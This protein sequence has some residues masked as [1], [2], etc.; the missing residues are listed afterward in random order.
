MH[1]PPHVPFSP[2]STRF[3]YGWVIL[4]MGTIG[5]LMSAPGQTVGV[6]P[7]TDFL[8]R[9]LGISRI[10][11]SLAYLIGTLSS[12]F[13]LSHAGRVYDV[14]GARLVGTVVAVA[15][16]LVLIALSAVPGIVRLLTG[17]VPA[18]PGVPT[19]FVLV[20]F[21]FFLLRF[22]GQ[23][24]L[25]L[26]SRNM[27]LKWFEA[28]RGLANALVGVATTVG[29]SSS[30]VIFNAMIDRFDWQ[31]AWRIL[32]IIV[33]VPFAVAF[34]LFSRDNP[35]ECGMEPDGGYVP[36]A[37]RSGRIRPETHPSAEFTLPQARRTLTFWVF[38]GVVTLSSMYFT[39]LTFNIVS[40]FEEA[41]MTRARAVSIFLPASVIALVL[42]LFGGWISDHIR[43]KYLATAQAAGILISTFAVF[44]LSTPATVLIL[45]I[46]NGINGGMFGI[47]VNVPWPRFYGTTHLGRISGF[48]MGWTVAGSAMG[49]YL[50]SLALSLFGSYGAASVI[51]TVVAAVLLV[52]TFFANR[53]DAPVILPGR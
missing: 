4:A 47:V 33:A 44:F 25:S 19:A 31:G 29:F 13:I 11:L 52:L 14:H 40:V 34:L 37:S 9:D 5:V 27:V 15:L 30:P 10:N 38:I 39:G 1:L 35:R 22:F 21:G 16:G 3:F 23:G 7:F 50:F 51:T 8:I 2:S 53:P 36:P 41:G 43:L 32:G 6:S 18:L 45:I 46:G 12:S 48:A 20:T 24:V 28:R 26:V 42:N 49:P 17:A